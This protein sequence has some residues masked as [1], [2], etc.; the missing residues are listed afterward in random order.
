[1]P[2]PGLSACRSCRPVGLSE[3]SDS[4]RKL[5]SACRTGALPAPR[6]STSGHYTDDYGPYLQG[7]RVGAAEASAQ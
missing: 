1:M 2:R 4:C 5:L 7:E 6:R 3:L